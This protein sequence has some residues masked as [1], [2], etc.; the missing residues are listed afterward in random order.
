MSAPSQ[1]AIQTVDTVLK[2]L[3]SLQESVSEITGNLADAQE[4][5]GSIEVTPS[6][7]GRLDSVLAQLQSGIEGC[8]GLTNYYNFQINNLTAAQ[9]RATVDVQASNVV[10]SALPA[11]AQEQQPA[12][13][14]PEMTDT[15][16]PRPGSPAW[17]ILQRTNPELA[18]QLTTFSPEPVAAEVQ[19]QVAAPVVA[20]KVDGPYDREVPSYAAKP[21]LTPA[22][23]APAET[24]RRSTVTRPTRPVSLQQTQ[25]AAPVADIGSL[26]AVVEQAQQPSKLPDP[27]PHEPQALPTMKMPPTGYQ[28]LTEPK[29]S[30]LIRA[31]APAPWLEDGT[32]TITVGTKNWPEVQEDIYSKN[33]FDR[34]RSHQGFYR[35]LGDEFPS[36]VLIRLR[37]FAV[38]WNFGTAPG[39]IE[40]Y[41]V[42]LSDAGTNDHRWFPAHTLPPSSI[43]RL[44]GEMHTILNVGE[45]VFNPAAA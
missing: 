11:V 9:Q 41:Q 35:N 4:T 32:G 43:L 13:Q 25:S 10:E 6:Q 8:N 34:V 21:E 30:P 23:A 36:S 40:V 17:R 42:G 39:D 38:L 27:V 7:Q 18:K 33:G 3:H 28:R 20:Q 37:T 24:T 26:P 15:H 12:P 31:F 29:Y 16:S 22:A 14:S 45:V 19:T 2:R 1:Q 5:L 44:L